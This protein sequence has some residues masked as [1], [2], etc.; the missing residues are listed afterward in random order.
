MRPI[1]AAEVV[2]KS[3]VRARIAALG[4]ILAACGGLA[5][6]VE[7]AVR[8]GTDCPDEEAV[9]APIVYRLREGGELVCAWMRVVSGPPHQGAMRLNCQRADAEPPSEQRRR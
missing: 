5:V 6:E 1:A 9:G 7:H 8:I 3:G 4:L 2:T